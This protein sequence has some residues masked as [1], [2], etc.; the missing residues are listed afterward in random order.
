MISELKQVRDNLNQSLGQ[1]A[2]FAGFNRSLGQIY[3]LLYL[4]PDNL[5]LSEIAETLGVSKGNVS[6]NTRLM[7]QWGLLRQF[8]RAADRRDYYEV[9][10][11][12]WKV[13]RGILQNRER[14]KITDIG[15]VLRKSLRDVEKL[16]SADRDAQFYQ[17]RLRHMLEFF[18]LFEQLFSAFLALDD[19]R[20]NNSLQPEE[21]GLVPPQQVDYDVFY[22]DTY[23]I[24]A[25]ALN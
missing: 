14:K 6:L 10:T 2:E 19:F 16:R 13:I 3:G 24:P 8:N 4:N 23:D 9:E 18:E 7:E 22:L 12:F 17:E 11:D 21:T 15:I 25:A 5:S 1:L 20:V